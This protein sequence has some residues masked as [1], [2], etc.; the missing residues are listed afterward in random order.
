MKTLKQII[1]EFWFPLTFAVLWTIL[2][3]LSVPDPSTGWQQTVLNC[4]GTFAPAFFFLS[5]LSGQ[6]FRVRKQLKVEGGLTSVEQRLT[7]LVGHMEQQ[8]NHLEKQAKDIVGYTTGGESYC[9]VLCAFDGTNPG[10]LMLMAIHC[11]EYP[12][13][14]IEIRVCD[15]DLLREGNALTIDRFFKI[16]RLL[17]DNNLM[18]GS[19]PMDGRN[20]R[21]FNIF[22]HAQNGRTVQEVRMVKSEAGWHQAQRVTRDYDTLYV[23]LVEDSPLG[24]NPWD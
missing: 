15:L 10:S 11:G 1:L 20:S 8:A 18:F 12:L 21:S 5:F 23:D 14:N 24:T 16:E 17:P 6:W 22:M 4:I 13:T 7:A 9:R 3:M 19:F 2:R